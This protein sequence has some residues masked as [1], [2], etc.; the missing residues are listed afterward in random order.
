MV[1]HYLIIYTYHTSFLYLN[2]LAFFLSQSSG[3]ERKFKCCLVSLQFEFCLMTTCIRQFRSF[4]QT[5]WVGFMFANGRFLPETKRAT[6]IPWGIHGCTILNIS[7]VIRG[8]STAILYLHMVYHYLFYYFKSKQK[9][10]RFTC[11]NFTN[12][13]KL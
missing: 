9:V 2:F 1:Y 10:C 13:K 6:V 12:K 8:L 5:F 7:H 4:V 3:G 11:H